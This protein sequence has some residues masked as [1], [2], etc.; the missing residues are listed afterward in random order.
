[1]ISISICEVIS[2][3]SE[4]DKQKKS[5]I[6]QSANGYFL[7]FSIDEIGKKKKATLGLRGMSLKEEDKVRSVYL[8]DAGD[9]SAHIIYKDKELYFTKLKLTSRDGRGT[10]VRR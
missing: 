7:R 2:L 8:C 10:K 6:L 5:I 3:F 4:D 1:M 9:T